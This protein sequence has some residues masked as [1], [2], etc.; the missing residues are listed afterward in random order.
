M[1]QMPVPHCDSCGLPINP[2]AGENCPRCGYPVSPPR[3]ERFLEGTIRNLQRVA[4]YGGANLTVAGLIQRYQSRL[5]YL[6]DI[7]STAA[8][9][10]VNPPTS[11]LEQKLVKMP[12]TNPFA[13]P[14]Q[15][16]VATS[17]VPQPG[18]VAPRSVFSWRSFFAD[19]S[20]NI[21]A[22]LGAFLILVG[23]LSFV[24]TT[25]NPW[26]SFLALFIVQAVFGI[27]GIGTYRFR[28]FRIVALIY[29]VIFALLIPLVGLSAYR[30]AA[31][32]LVPLSIPTLVAIAAI[33]A[34]TVYILL[35]NYQ[36]VATFAYPGL[37][38]LLLADLAI[39][40]T[41]TLGYWWWSVTL[42]LLAFPALISIQH[43][44]ANGRSFTGNRAILRTPMRIFMYAT[45]AICTLGTVYTAFYSTLIGTTIRQAAEVRYSILIMTLLLLLWASLALCLTRLA[46]WTLILAYLFLACVLA[47]CYALDF[48]PIGYTLALTGV[49]LLYHSL[50]RFAGRWLQQFGVLSIGLDQLALA[51]ACI[52]PFIASP[53]LLFQLLY[54][55]Y[56]ISVDAN[57]PFFFQTSWLTVA[58]L[59]AVGFGLLLTISTTM[60]RAGFQKTLARAGWCWLF[61]LSGF[62]L[63]W[64]YALLVLMLNAVPT[65]YFLGLALV[66]VAGTVFVRQRIGAV[67][68]NPLD[69]LAL[70]EMIFTLILALNI[71]E[72]AVIALLLCFAALTYG[73][74]V[75]Q[76][77][78]VWLFL[79]LVFAILALPYLLDHSIAML[80]L[81]LLLPPV[82]VAIQ[83]F[84]SGN[85]NAPI[86]GHPA[87][88][89]LFTR[90]EWPLL[91][92]ALIYGLV[93]SLHDVSLDTSTVQNVS[94]IM[95]PIAL[96]ITLLS[97]SWFIFATASR[98]KIWLL[99]ATGFAIGALLIPTNVFWALV[100]LTP[101]AA[102][103]ATGIKRFAGRDWALP[104]YIVAVLAA[105]M[106]GY[107]GAAQNHQSILHWVLLGYTVLA[108]IVM[109]V[110]RAPEMLVFPAAL[111]GWTIVEWQ[112]PL[113]IATLMIAYSLL[114][115]LIFASQFVWRVIP[116]TTR[117]LSASSLHTTLGLGGQIIVLLNIIAL[118]GLF[119]K[120]GLLAHVG[121][122]A[123]LELVI[124]LFWYGQLY[125]GNIMR[126]LAAESDEGKRDMRK[127]HARRVRHWCNYGGGLLLS[128]AVS[129]E[130]S[131]LHQTRLDLL[132]LAPAS[133]LSI[134][135]AFIMRDEALTGRHR[136]AQLV[137]ISGAAI[138]LLPT[139]WLS[140]ND[141]N[142]L[143][144]LILL[145]EAIALLCLGIITRVRNQAHYG[146]SNLD[147]TTSSTLVYASV[148]MIIVGAMRALFLTGQG[149]PVVLTTGGL[150]L[151]AFATALKLASGRFLSK[152]NN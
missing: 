90:W 152:S 23:S 2:Q 83:R 110:E 58:Q 8:I 61:L 107:T 105:V 121:A 81:A 141:S 87:K 75:Y 147:N 47:F 132:S 85:R 42:M 65:W 18:Q 25:N 29:T 17:A 97:L 123:L 53:F 101:A 79:P 114:C 19:Q 12:V 118:G 103:L 50:N 57:S 106:T 26:T 59:V 145:V 100:V 89:Q 5:K 21:V 62:L 35:A 74:L 55:A 113:Q 150:I 34:A 127:Q 3:E 80:V 63:N 94:G 76:H 52:V 149:V 137:S 40:R 45:V 72:V 32:N 28:T 60:S 133:Y 37:A 111:A 129:W 69:I 125:S 13:T 126:M 143:S 77:R 148:S 68:S 131:A 48:Q 9:T 151:V 27:V 39:A 31:G 104:L 84:V 138:L 96:E 64:E 16:Q 119:A 142:L 93:F 36:Q 146:S 70:A 54:R 99:P 109:L 98:M 92:A 49:A 7:S 43:L 71:S 15:Q 6:Q 115:V 44:S 51:L 136:V 112:P 41:F 67:W 144:T 10:P 116:P 46:K 120:S 95:F 73:I 82:S 108:L 1:S 30:L 91:V 78:L 33:Y 122:G 86:A 66:L 130:L 139:L 56:G 102:L 22:S 38:S 4:T 88:L 20:I 24:V 140:F 128:L 14:A 11:L 124:L 135:S 134:V 117:W